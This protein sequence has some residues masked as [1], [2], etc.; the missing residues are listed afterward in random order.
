MTQML[1][2]GGWILV[3]LVAMPG[4]VLSFY[5]VPLNLAAVV[6][7]FGIG[8]VSS[9]GQFLDAFMLTIVV[10]LGLAAAFSTLFGPHLSVVAL[11]SV[12]L[13]A[14]LLVMKCGAL[15]G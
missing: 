3:A 1:L 6:L 15:W 8:F 11:A 13:A 5:V 10:G 4:W 7:L 14:P 2:R 9:R 12:I